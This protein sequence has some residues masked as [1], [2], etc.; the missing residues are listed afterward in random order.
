MADT[1]TSSLRIA[2]QTIGGNE[3]TWGDILNASLARLDQ[4]VAGVV[5]V[6]VTA[7]NVALSTANNADDQARNALIV[8]TGTPGVTR[9]VTFPDVEKLTWVYNNSD[10]SAT[11]TAGAGTTVSV[12][13]GSIALIYTDAATNAAGILIA[14]VGG[15]HVTTTASQTLTNK[16]LTSPSLTGTVTLPGGS[17]L[18]AGG[19]GTGEAMAK[20]QN[21]LTAFSVAN[22]STGTAGRAAFTASNSASTMLMQQLSTGF[23]PAGV[24]RADG[25][26]LS[27]TGAGGVTVHA[28]HASGTVYIGINQTQVAAFDATKLDLAIGQIKFPSSQLASADAN[29]LDD[30][31]EGTFTPTLGDGTNNYTLSIAIGSYTKTGDTVHAHVTAVWSSIGSAGAAQLRVGAMPFTSISTANYR[32]GVAW[33]SVSGLDTTATLNQITGLMLNSATTVGFER[34]NDNAASTAL[35]ANGSSA[36]GWMMLSITYKI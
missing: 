7:G 30:Y 35:A 36:S 33:A 18:E 4:A 11:L 5:S 34:A 2:Q 15:T 28:N 6:S 26:V 32:F 29:T 12:P 17:T 23:T 27:G 21:T 24:N 25:G 16:T 31:E 10:S 20:S 3:N 9:T 13:A 22:T 1:Y 19:G 14:P 8:L